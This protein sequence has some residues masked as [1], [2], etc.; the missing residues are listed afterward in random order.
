MLLEAELDRLRTLIG[1]IESG[2]LGGSE[3]WEGLHLSDRS[4]VGAGSEAVENSD[5]DGDGDSD[6]LKGNGRHHKQPK[7]H[8]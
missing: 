6:T 7:G 2:A 8:R 1:D 3:V 5:G 4:L